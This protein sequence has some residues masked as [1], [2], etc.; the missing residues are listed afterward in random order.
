M[1][2]N[3]NGFT[4]FFQLTSYKWTLALF[5]FEKKIWLCHFTACHNYLLSKNPWKLNS[6]VKV[7]GH[8][9]DLLIHFVKLFPRNCYWPY[10]RVSIFKII[11]LKSI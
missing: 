4:V 1:D 7:Y 5:F 6:W 3:F 2:K 10:V 11:E 8:L 9:L